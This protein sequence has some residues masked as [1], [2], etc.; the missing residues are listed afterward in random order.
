M[1]V[2]FDR[3]VFKNKLILKRLFSSSVGSKD[4]HKPET[5]EIDFLFLKI[6]LL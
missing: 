3:A 2:I 4:S 5:A 6:M 1:V